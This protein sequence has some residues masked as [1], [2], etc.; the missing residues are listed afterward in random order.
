MPVFVSLLP[1]RCVC[2]C[3]LPCLAAAYRVTAAWHDA[4]CCAVAVGSLLPVR[5]SSMHMQMEAARAYF[6]EPACPAHRN[7]RELRCSSAALDRPPSGQLHAALQAQAPPAPVPVSAG[8]REFEFHPLPDSRSRRSSNNRARASLALRLDGTQDGGSGGCG[9][10]QSSKAEQQQPQSHAHACAAPAGCTKP[11]AIVAYPT[12]GPAAAAAGHTTCVVGAAEAVSEADAAS[13]GVIWEGAVTPQRRDSLEG[14][15][16]EFESE[17]GSQW[18]WG[19]PAHSSASP[20]SVASQ[21][22]QVARAAIPAAAAAAAAGSS[23]AGGGGPAAG[24]GQEQEEPAMLVGSAP[25]AS[26]GAIIITLCAG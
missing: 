16:P 25:S 13:E 15:E 23:P 7:S 6:L 1:L 10:M 26:F 4:H 12:G 18:Y 19:S 14:E 24:G 22:G 5:A 9:G 2:C 17:F 8:E 3:L 21:A 11:L 20:P